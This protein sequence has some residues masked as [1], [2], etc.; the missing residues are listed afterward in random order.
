MPQPEPLTLPRRAV[1]AAWSGLTATPY[2]LAILAILASLFR[3][4]A[5]M[6]DSWEEMRQISLHW[7]DPAAIVEYGGHSAS[8]AWLAILFGMGGLTS[9][10]ANLTAHVVTVVAVTAAAFALPGIRG[11]VPRL[12]IWY[13]LWVGG[14]VVAALYSWLGGYDVLTVTGIF[15]GV[16]ARSKGVRAAGWALAGVNHPTVAVLAFAVWLPWAWWQERTTAPPGIPAT[17]PVHLFARPFVGVAAGSAL[18]TLIASVWHVPTR[19]EMYS[20]L[21]GP[22]TFVQY[23]GWRQA[24]VMLVAAL[25]AGWLLLA[26]PGTRTSWPV[27]ALAVL[28]AATAVAI[29]MIALDHTR[30]VGLMLLPAALIVASVVPSRLTAKQARLAGLVMLIGGTLMVVP[31][32]INPYA[33]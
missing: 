18:N 29:P 3:Y 23:Y 9:L 6:M 5:V 16:T 15:A 13:G 19:L 26:L 14:P 31:F 28:A 24:A 21:G 7:S 1:S 11:S 12:R 2:G 25:G 33:V 20:A 32:H 10:V 22:A 27:R 4:D 8:N 30:I 17:R